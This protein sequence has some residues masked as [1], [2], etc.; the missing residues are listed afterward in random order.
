MMIFGLGPTELIVILAIV[1]L[2]F[3]AKKIP[4]LARGLG[5]GITEFKRGLKD[6]SKVDDDADE[7]PEDT[8]DEKNE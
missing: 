1:F 3:G 6:T 7:I 8:K 5:K 4:Q 2:L